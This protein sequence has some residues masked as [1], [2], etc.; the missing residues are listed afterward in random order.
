MA[1]VFNR[2]TEWGGGVS[3]ESTRMGFSG[4]TQGLLIQNVDIQYSQTISRLYA[5]ESGLVYFVAG[6]TNG[7]MSVGHVIGPQG[8]MDQFWAKY[9]DVCNPE[10]HINIALAAG[11]LSKVSQSRIQLTR[12]VISNIGISANAQNM[13]IA[14]NFVASFVALEVKKDTNADGTVGTL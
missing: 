9:G 11:C 8:L 13:Q 7:Q 1:D 10:S 14:S 3:A 5:L 6:Q 2:T 12:P 4:V